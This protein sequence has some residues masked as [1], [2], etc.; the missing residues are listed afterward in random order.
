MGN[1]P[2]RESRWQQDTQ[3]MPWNLRLQNA[4]Q[5][6]SRCWNRHFAEGCF[7]LP[8]KKICIFK[9]RQ[10]SQ[11]ENEGMSSAP[12]QENGEQ[13]H[14]EELCYI[15]INHRV[16]GARPSG[17]SAEEYYENISH[18]PGKPRETPA[19][20]ETEY[21]LLRVPPTPRHPP[22]PEDEYELLM[23]SR[24]PCHSLQQPHSRMAS[25][26]TS[27]SCLQ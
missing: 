25:L 6:A 23:P 8:W 14:P 9:A 19:A 4:K 3:Q 24:I 1:F 27:V 21:S 22:S 15:L 18:Q 2:R 13:T 7:C 11:K 10:D 5:R 20:T 12:I 26:E 17:S 16:L